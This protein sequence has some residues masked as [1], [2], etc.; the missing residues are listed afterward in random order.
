MEETAA[1]AVTL[2]TACASFDMLLCSVAAAGWGVERSVPSPH[3]LPPLS[4]SGVSG[5]LRL[6][7]VEGASGWGT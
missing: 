5:V 6:C 4:A 2:C 3:P 7:G 1:A